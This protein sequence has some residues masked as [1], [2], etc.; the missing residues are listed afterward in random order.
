MLKGKLKFPGD[1][2][3]SHRALIL[4]ALTNSDCK[5]ENISTGAD[6]ESTRNCIALCGIDSKRTGK[7]V[8]LTRG[9]LHNPKSNLN[10]GNSGT[11]A[12]LLIGL[13]AG[14]K[15][16]A[17]FVGDESLSQRPMQ[18]IIHPLEKMGA[19]FESSDQHFPLTLHS[20]Q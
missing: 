11:T 19:K 8:S 1:K 7:I 3:I 14:Q 6:V 4:A 12:R 13:L 20:K 15:V 10:C 5:I 18:R 9:Q 17:R 2:S 16:S